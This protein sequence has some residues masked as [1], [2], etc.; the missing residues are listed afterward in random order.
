MVYCELTQVS[1]SLSFLSLKIFLSLNNFSAKKVCSKVYCFKKT[2]NINAGIDKFKDPFSIDL[3]GRNLL[4]LAV[5]G[6]FFFI[7]ALLF[8]YRYFEKL[9]Y[10]VVMIAVIKYFIVFKIL[11]SV[12]A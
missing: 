4:A 7:L 9:I 1:K 12:L 3:V 11:L 5:E 10:Y 8:Q 6:V 2:M